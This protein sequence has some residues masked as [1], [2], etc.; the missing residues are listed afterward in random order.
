[1]AAGS[2]RRGRADYGRKCRRTGSIES[3]LVRVRLSRFDNADLVIGE[4]VVRARQVDLGHVARRAIVLRHAADF[5]VQG[6]RMA[7]RALRIVTRQI[8]VD[9]PMRIVAGSA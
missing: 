3:M 7:G 1:G 9:L 8:G 4:L 2:A 6:S 5:G